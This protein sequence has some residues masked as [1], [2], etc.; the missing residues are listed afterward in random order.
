MDSNR[1][2]VT[3]PVDA[4]TDLVTRAVRAETLLEE[5]KTKYWLLQDN[6]NKLK[7]SLEAAAN[8]EETTA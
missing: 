3:I 4:Y 5:M 7:K 1:N 8:T 6:H 2:Y